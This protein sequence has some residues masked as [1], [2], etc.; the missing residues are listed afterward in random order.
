MRTTKPTKYGLLIDKGA[1]SENDIEK[2]QKGQFDS[3]MRLSAM[4]THDLKNS[5]LTLSLIVDNM[6]EQFDK[7]E[8]R[9]DAMKSRH[10]G[11]ISPARSS[12]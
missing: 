12:G 9:A 4:L 8:F 10:F 11:M 2:M 1:V 6:K 7:E 3:F 5:I